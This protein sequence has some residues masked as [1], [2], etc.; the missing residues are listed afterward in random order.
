M[1][2][3]DAGLI[4]HI[5]DY[6][7]LDVAR[8]WQR[9]PLLVLPTPSVAE[10]LEHGGR[11][12]RGDLECLPWEDVVLDVGTARKL[13]PLVTTEDRVLLEHH[14]RLSDY[15]AIVYEASVAVSESSE[16]W[17]EAR[18]RGAAWIRIRVLA[19]ALETGIPRTSP[20]LD[21][22]DDETRAQGDAE[23]LLLVE[24]WDSDTVRG[25]DGAAGMTMHAAALAI[26]SGETGFPRWPDCAIVDRYTLEQRH[27]YSGDCRDRAHGIAWCNLHRCK[28]RIADPQCYS[29][30]GVVGQ[31]TRL[32]IAV[33][34]VFADPPVYVVERRPRVAPKDRPRLEKTQRLK[35]WARTDLATLILVDPS[36]V[37]ELGH[38]SAVTSSTRATPRL[39]QRRGHWRTIKRA[40]EE[41]RRTWI[42]PAWVGADAWE[43]EGTAYQLA[44]F[45]TAAAL[46]RARAP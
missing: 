6:H 15:A 44:Q 3:T 43:H 20:W 31:M 38:P 22:I 25:A 32:A 7:G 14:A 21:Q 35:P 42:R 27:L 36:R 2:R 4:R 39:H 10:L 19:R 1:T 18:H 23:G 16:E 40:T 11:M 41:E 13:L 46:A 12:R 17:D 8:E 34:S 33:L 26:E 30:V 24:A 29:G 45:P 5:A 9:P 37:E 28:H